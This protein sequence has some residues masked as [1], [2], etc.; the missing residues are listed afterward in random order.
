MICFLPRL[1]KASAK[2]LL[3]GDIRKSPSGRTKTENDYLSDNQCVKC[4]YLKISLL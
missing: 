2:V 4:K 1:P 3:F